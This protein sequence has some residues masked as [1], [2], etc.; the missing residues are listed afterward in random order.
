M[1]SEASMPMTF[2]IC[3]FALSGSAPGRSILLMTGMISRPASTARCALAS[4]CASTPW[5]ASTTS[6]APWQAAR[7]A[8]HLVGEVHVARRVDQVE[9]VVLAVPRPVVEPH[10]VLLDGD[11]ALALQVHRVEELLGHL[12]LG[13]R[14][15][16]LHQPV[17][18]RGLAVVDV[19]DDREV[20]DVLHGWQVVPLCRGAAVEVRQ[21]GHSNPRG[22]PTITSMP[23]PARKK[24]A[25]VLVQAVASARSGSSRS[26]MTFS[27]ALGRSRGALRVGAGHDHGDA[28]VHEGEQ[29]LV[30]VPAPRR[31]SSVGPSPAIAAGSAN[32]ARAGCAPGSARSPASA[33][34]SSGRGDSKSRRLGSS[35]HA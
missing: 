18:E 22:P 13:E 7:R 21:T 29:E 33:A 12:A 14:A 23:G 3:S 10:G 32:R 9:D 11:A 6:S 16:A 35:T 2:S 1:A 4:V 17:G 26:A 24:P 19:R 20:T 27:T 8:A 28:P 5:L 25:A 15:R 30:L 34:S 31:A